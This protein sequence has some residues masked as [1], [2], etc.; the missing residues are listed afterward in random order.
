MSSRSLSAHHRGSVI[1]WAMASVLTL[2][3]ALLVFPLVGVSS[4]VSFLLGIAATIVVLL[5]N[6]AIEGSLWMSHD[7]WSEIFSDPQA[8]HRLAVLS[9]VI[10]LVVESAVILYVIMAPGV[11]EALFS[12]I[13]QRQCQAPTSS[14]FAEVCQSLAR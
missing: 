3:L 12:L 6:T 13:L 7:G 9:G 11:D 4:L 10:L 5:M 8:A 14:L 1:F 2:P